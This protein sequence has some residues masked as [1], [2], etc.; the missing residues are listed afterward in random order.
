MEIRRVEIGD[1]LEQKA[2]IGRSIAVDVALHECI[3]SIP[4]FVAKLSRRSG[5]VARA[6]E[7]E[8][9]V[10]S[11]ARMRVNPG[12]INHVAFVG[13]KV[14]DRVPPGSVE[15]RL[16]DRLEHEGV[17]AVAADDLVGTGPATQR[18]VACAAVERI[19]AAFTQDRVVPVAAFDGVAPLTAAEHVIAIKPGDRVVALAAR[20]DVL[21][22]AADDPVVEARADRI[23]NGGLRGQDRRVLDYGDD[24]ARVGLKRHHT[25]DAKLV[26]EAIV[27]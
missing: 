22:R 25:T 5:K 9:L 12:Q 19:V 3:G 20:D 4:Q 26:H 23:L 18:V 11:G 27:D 7:I 8:S 6:D 13:R 17:A 15:R 16:R 14:A 24:V 10:A 21:D 1:I 2:E